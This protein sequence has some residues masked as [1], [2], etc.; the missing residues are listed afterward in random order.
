M[1]PRAT[2]PLNI[3]EPRYLNMIDDALAGDRLIGMVQPIGPGD[4]GKPAVAQVGCAGR[5][6]SFA[7]TDDGRYLITLTGV[8]RF[9]VRDELPARTPYRCVT[10]DWERYGADLTPPG[11]A[12]RVDRENLVRALRR[13]VDMHGFQAE[14]SVI[15][16]APPEALIH[17]LCGLCPFE[18][19]EKQMLIEAETLADRCQM[20][21]ALLDMNS[22]PDV[23]GPMQ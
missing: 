13:Y 21:I 19:R 6:T 22:A 20:L 4:P 12:Y 16:D 9:A 7:E 17:T 8:A 2:L 14:W 18:P 10:P 23:K 3:F 5:I 11:D 15:D 1:L